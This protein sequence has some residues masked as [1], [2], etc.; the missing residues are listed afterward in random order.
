MGIIGGIIQG[1]GAAV[2]GIAGGIAGRRAAKRNAKI[3]DRQEQRAQDW[4]D[5]EY[6]SDFTQRSDAQ[7]A[8]NNA[9][10]ILENQYGQTK[11]A[12]AVSGATDESVAQ[13]KA[14]NNQVLADITSNIA[15][16]ADTYKDQVRANYENQ[17][18]NIE[19]Q[20]MAVN[21][22]R[23]QNAANAASGLAKAANA[24]GAQVEK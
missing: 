10:Q 22:Q 16:R 13:Q 11:G 12:A 6:N 19:Q 21:N 17:M 1:A 20:R 23:A 7:A 15:E 3:L 2:A 5:K 14:A 18:A 9:R 4:Y 8:L 24:I